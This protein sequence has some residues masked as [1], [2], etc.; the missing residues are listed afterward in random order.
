LSA[1]LTAQDQKTASLPKN[2]A[3]QLP[4]EGPIEVVG[5]G[6]LVDRDFVIEGAPISATLALSDA[7][8]PVTSIRFVERD[9][10]DIGMGGLHGLTLEIDWAEGRYA[11]TGTA[12]QRESVQRRRQA[13]PAST[14]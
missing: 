14:D 3:D 1:D 5:R 8:I 4:L 12:E 11:L 10:R 13:P 7:S 2:Y 9:F 6:R